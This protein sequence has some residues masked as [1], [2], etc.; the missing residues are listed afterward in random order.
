MF[1]DMLTVNSL[2]FEE[3][4]SF[5]EIHHCHTSRTRAHAILLSGIGFKLKKIASIYN[6]YRQTAAK[7]LHALKDEGIC[8]LFDKPRSGRPRL[9]HNKAEIDAITRVNQSPRSLKKCLL[10]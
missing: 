8:G 3:I 10:N 6:I 9:L 7:W 4:K 1:Y 5:D 2:P